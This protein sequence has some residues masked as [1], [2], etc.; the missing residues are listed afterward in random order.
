MKLQSAPSSQGR[1]GVPRGPGA[2]LVLGGWCPPGAAAWAQ[3]Q[4]NSDLSACCP[5]HTGFLRRLRGRS[6]G[7]GG[8]RAGSHHGLCFLFV[9]TKSL[10]TGFLQTRC[11]DASPWGTWPTPTSAG[12]E[13]GSPSCGES[14]G[15]CKFRRVTS[16]G[17]LL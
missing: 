10:T 2:S 17:V 4:G 7:T 8:A 12:A 16:K 14:A 15:R 11:P 1:R 3:E 5:R 6:P 9:S 13:S